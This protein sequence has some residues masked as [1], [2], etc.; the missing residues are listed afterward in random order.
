MINA[1][2]TSLALPRYAYLGPGYDASCRIIEPA[3]THTVD[4]LRLQPGERVFLEQRGP[5][6][7]GVAAWTTGETLRAASGLKKTHD[8]CKEALMYANILVPVDGSTTSNLGLKEAIRLALDQKARLYVLHIKD[9]RH[10]HRHYAGL[11]TLETLERAAHEAGD[12][13]LNTAKAIAQ[14]SGTDA[15]FILQETETGEVAHRIIEQAKR[16]SV[17][18]IVMGTHGRRGLRHVLL[19]SEAEGVVRMAPVPVLLVR[20]E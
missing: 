8:V 14:E 18:L 20:G 13:I 16:L 6:N 17:D 1:P 11:V 9:L 5:R 19:G 12:K 2:D 3:R 10:A 4:L 15:E 7:D